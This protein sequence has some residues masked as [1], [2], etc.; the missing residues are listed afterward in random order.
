[1]AFYLDCECGEQLT[2]STTQAGCELQCSC[3]LVL[4]VPSLGEMNRGVTTPT[5]ITRAANGKA[6]PPKASLQSEPDQRADDECPFCG[7]TMERGAILGDRYK[8][9]WLP[10]D[11]SLALGIWAVTAES[12]GHKTLLSRPRID[13]MKCTSCRKIVVDY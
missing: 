10:D 9:K 6:P 1:M 11:E 8:L 13:G 7:A 2:V 5:T 4:S 12:I 3:G